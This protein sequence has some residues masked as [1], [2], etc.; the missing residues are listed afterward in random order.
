MRIIAQVALI[1]LL[2]AAAAAQQPTTPPPAPT[3]PTPVV[4]P[5]PVITPVDTATPPAVAAP[6]AAAPADSIATIKPGMTL[7]EVEAAWGRASTKHVVGGHMFLYYTND[8]AKSCGTLDV[9]ILENGRVTDAIVRASYHRYDGVSSSP[10][11]R[12]PS[13][14]P[15]PG[16]TP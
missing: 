7:A 1:M 3:T 15:P 13:F 12:K 4:V 10:A 11:G 6:A 16:N 14:T 9:V 2:P 5:A 8:C